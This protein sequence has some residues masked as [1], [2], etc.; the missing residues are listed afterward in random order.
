MPKY[1]PTQIEDIVTWKRDIM[2]RYVQEL[3]KDGYYPDY[4]PVDFDYDAGHI[5]SNFILLFPTK[6][7]Q[8]SRQRKPPLLIGFLGEKVQ[9]TRDC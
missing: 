6:E 5:S 2:N 7:G 8:P 4:H 3:A 9:K 1:Y